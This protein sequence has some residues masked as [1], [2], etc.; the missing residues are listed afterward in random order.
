L[1][2]FLFILFRSNRFAGIVNGL[3]KEQK[4]VGVR[5]ACRYVWSETKITTN[6]YARNIIRTL[7]RKS[8]LPSEHLKIC[9]VALICC[10]SIN[11]PDPLKHKEGPWPLQ[12]RTHNLQSDAPDVIVTASNWELISS[13]KRGELF[14]FCWYT[15]STY[16]EEESG[17]IGKTEKVD[18]RGKR[19]KRRNRYRKKRIQKF[20]RF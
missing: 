14:G 18:K 9:K 16:R 11:M 20:A 13:L 2:E 19:R 4:T 10:R 12:L 6:I 3:N 17:K 5:S 8:L 1:I 15:Y 7:D